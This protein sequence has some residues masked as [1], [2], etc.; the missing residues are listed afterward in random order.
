MNQRTILGAAGALLLAVSLMATFACDSSSPTAPRST[1]NLQIRLT[2]APADELSEVNVYISGLTIK[3]SGSAVERIAND[4]GLFELLSLQDTSVLLIAVGV[5]PGEYEFI[6]VDLDEGRSYVVELTGGVES[7]LKIPS[8]EIKVLGK[9]VVA[10]NG[11]TEVLLDFDAAASIVKLGNSDW[12][13]TPVI[14]IA[15]VSQS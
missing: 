14:S 5:E 10:E 4:V 6:Q 8:R 11:S 9:F 2:D 1:G 7:P 15:N 13:M 12:L 3:R